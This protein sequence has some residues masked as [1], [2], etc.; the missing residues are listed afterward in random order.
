[1]SEDKQQGKVYPA[2]FSRSTQVNIRKFYDEDG[3]LHVHDPNKRWQSYT[4][5]N[6]HTY[7]VVKKR[8]ASVDT[9]GKSEIYF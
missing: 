7:E 8:N 2:L 5:S 3:K 1:M 4:C 6:G 9:I